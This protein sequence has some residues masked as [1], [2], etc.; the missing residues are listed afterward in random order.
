MRMRCWALALG[1]VSWLVACGGDISVAPAGAVVAT[2]GTPGLESPPGT[3][4]SPGTPDTEPTLPSAPPPST[5]DQQL[6]ASVSPT[7]P[8]RRVVTTDDLDVIGWWK[9]EPA[10]GPPSYG[11]FSGSLRPTAT[12]GHFESEDSATW[13]LPH[14]GLRI[15]LFGMDAPVNGLSQIV[16]GDDTATL[17]YVALAHEPLS[18]AQRSGRYA[19]ELQLP[20]RREPVSLRW[21]IDG[22]LRLVLTDLPAAD[23]VGTGQAAPKPGAPVRV[24]AVELSF[25]GNGCPE[26]TSGVGLAGATVTGAIDAESADS[27]VLFG[28]DANRQRALLLPAM[29][30]PEVALQ[31]AWTGATGIFGGLRFAMLNDHRFVG[32]TYDPDYG[33]TG[34]SAHGVVRGS[35]P[36]PS[37]QAAHFGGGPLRLWVPSDPSSVPLMNPGLIGPLPV[38]ESM[39]ATFSVSSMDLHDAPIAHLPLSSRV[40]SGRYAGVLQMAGLR[41]TA[42]LQWGSDDALI[43]R[44]DGYPDCTLSGRA[45]ELAGGPARWRS[46]HMVFTGP[47]CPIGLGNRPLEGMAISGAID[48]RSGDEFVLF[49]LDDGESVALVLPATRTP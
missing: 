23:C 40:R 8:Q 3:P 20:G 33:G 39:N 49:G 46:F 19:G 43:V 37:V 35:V 36:P 5:L 16:H 1:L 27:F 32:W 21:S 22:Q 17:R 34:V 29:R 4:G 14:E 30:V 41:S 24:L 7:G 31:G 47:G 11:V 15:G 13:G 9:E 45:A 44:M 10:S 28:T 18:M 12:A 48:A 26:L 2:Q 25:V 6:W 42:T 38:S